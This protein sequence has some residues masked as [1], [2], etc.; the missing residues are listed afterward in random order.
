MMPT[1][2]CRRRRRRCDARSMR[3]ESAKAASAQRAVNSVAAMDSMSAAAP[4]VGCRRGRRTCRVD[5]GRQRTYVRAA[6]RRLDRRALHARACRRR[7]SSRSRKRTSI[8]CRALPE[9]RA[10]FALGDRVIVVGR[11]RAIVVAAT[12]A[13]P[14]LSRLGARDAREGV[15]EER[16]DERHRP[17]LSRIP[18]AARAISHAAAR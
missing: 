8:W 7:R 12:T 2:R 3:F 13:S 14:S 5:A 15:V 6:R 16:A 1:Q 10:V 9:L 18:P 11:D 17:P 4:S